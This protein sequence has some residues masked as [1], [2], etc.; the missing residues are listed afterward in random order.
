MVFAPKQRSFF[1]GNC[2]G[3]CKTLK[4]EEKRETELYM[5]EKGIVHKGNHWKVRNPWV[6]DPRQ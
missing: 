5:V 3:D 1:C 2:L 4:R 6:R